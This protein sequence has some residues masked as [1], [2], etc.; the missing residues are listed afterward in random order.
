MTS[1]LVVKWSKIVSKRYEKA[2]ESSNFKI[3]ATNS[4]LDEFFIMFTIEGG[5]Y[6]GQ[7]HILSFKTRWGHPDVQYFPFSAPLVSF[8]TKIY[9]PNISPYGSICVDILTNSNQWSPQNDFDSVISSILLLLDIP[10]CSSPL[11]RDAATDYI[12]CEQVYKN[13]VTKNI[14]FID[15]EKLQS[16]CFKTYYDKAESYANTDIQHYIKMFASL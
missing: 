6:K 14:S 4:V 9:H 13:K 16:E 11:N 10:N 7:T 15:N 8:L 12:K 1:K 5:M 2:K 3:I